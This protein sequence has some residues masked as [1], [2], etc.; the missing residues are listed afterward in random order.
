[1][2]LLIGVLALW[3]STLGVVALDKSMRAR[4]RASSDEMPSFAAEPSWGVLAVLCVL[5]NVAALPYYFYATRRS[6]LW[7]LVGCGAFV[8]CVTVSV[9]TFFAA[10]GS[11][12]F[13][14]W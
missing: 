10:G 8:G 2:S 5:M 4:D 9:V 14:R 11:A 7:G 13:L 3:A 1:M 12:I 6:A